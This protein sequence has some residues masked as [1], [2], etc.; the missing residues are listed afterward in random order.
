MP[1]ERALLF[2]Q[3]NVL[4]GR[5]DLEVDYISTG[6]SITPGARAYAESATGLTKQLNRA[7]SRVLF[8]QYDYILLPA[9]NLSWPWDRSRKKHLRDLVKILLAMIRTARVRPFGKKPVVAI[10]DRYDDPN[11]HME[12]PCTT[13]ADLYFKSNLRPSLE[14][15]LPFQVRPLPLWLFQ[16]KYPDISPEKTADVFYCADNNSSHRRHVL[17]ELPAL[18]ALGVIVDHPQKR[19]PFPEFVER[20][21]RAAITLSP[22]G[23][24]Y[25]GFRHYEA[26]LMKSVPAINE[27]HEPIGTDLVKDENYL[28]YNSNVQ[29]DFIRT[30][31]RALETRPYLLKWGQAL[32]PFTL[33]RHTISA[34]GDYLLAEL[35]RFKAAKAGR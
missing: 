12:V 27:Y 19:I 8:R 24:G 22:T 16:E 25:N 34:V 26:M 32:R 20:M 3:D 10:M 18:I 6:P 21:S 33:E 2:C 11:L 4:A 28:V 5:S 15:T 35:R 7:A 14:G 30:I 13:R 1:S 17:N 29:G 23:Y 31:S 9:I